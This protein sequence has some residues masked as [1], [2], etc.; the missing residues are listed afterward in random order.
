MVF[1]RTWRKR[2]LNRIIYLEGSRAVGK[3]TL[4]Q[5]VKRQHP[6]YI[7]IDGSA[8]KEYSF[9]NSNLDEYIINE[10]LYLACNVSQYEVLKSVDTTVIIVK[11]P[12]TDAFYAEK[13]GEE[14]FGDAF[15]K[16]EDLKEYLEKAKE[17]E[18]DMII[19]LDASE[20]EILSRYKN[21]KKIRSSMPVFMNNWLAPFERFYKDNTKT[22]IID[23]N[24]KT[25]EEVCI[26]FLRLIEHG[27]NR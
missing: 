26:E 1:L 13:F 21:D 6:D 22:R 16:R 5:N 20:E 24:G 23:T 4:L 18:P 19:Y 8:R 9:N 14:Q 27:E 11:G 10:K 12:Y 7:V 2:L 25:A 17:C 3:T 15:W